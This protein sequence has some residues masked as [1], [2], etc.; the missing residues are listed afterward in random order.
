MTSRLQGGHAL[1]LQDLCAGLPLDPLPQLLPRDPK[2]PHAPVR[3]SNLSQQQRKAS[4]EFFLL[5]CQF[6]QNFLKN[7]FY[8][9]LAFSMLDISH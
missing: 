5:S 6:S 8:L 4:P 2:V 3:N 1:T 7:V 9:V